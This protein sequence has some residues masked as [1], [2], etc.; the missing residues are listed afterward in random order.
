[1]RVSTVRF[2]QLLRSAKQWDKNFPALCHAQTEWLIESFAYGDA[3]SVYVSPVDKARWDV[4]RLAD[5]HLHT[6]CK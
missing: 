6:V 4:P 2:A 5:G 3:L 1:M